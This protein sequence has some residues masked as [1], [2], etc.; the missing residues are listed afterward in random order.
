MIQIIIDIRVSFYMR[1]YIL[2]ILFLIAGDEML[3]WLREKVTGGE[4]ATSEETSSYGKIYLYCIC[5]LFLFFI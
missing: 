2:Y 5:M 1:L 3:S 4:S